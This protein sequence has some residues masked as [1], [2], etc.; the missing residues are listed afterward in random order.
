M[1]NLQALPDDAL[2]FHEAALRR[3]TGEASLENEIHAGNKE[4]NLIKEE[5]MRRIAASPRFKSK[6]ERQWKR[7]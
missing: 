7:K 3:R 6:E 5:W 4:L 2:Y 1:N